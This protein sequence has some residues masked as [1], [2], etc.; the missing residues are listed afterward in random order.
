YFQQTRWQP[1]F[2]W[3]EYYFSFFSNLLNLSKNLFACSLLNV[4]GGNSLM[5]YL[6]DAP[7]KICSFNNSFSLS[8]STRFSNSI[9]I[10]KPLP[11]TDMI[12]GIL[13]SSS[14]R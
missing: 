3:I 9:P 12:S 14:S 5:M 6:P 7:V 1:D 11:L 13:L 4:N 10:I 8:S 2:G